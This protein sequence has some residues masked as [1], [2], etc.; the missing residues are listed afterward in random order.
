MLNYFLVAISIISLALSSYAY[1]S[2]VQSIFQWKIAK[3][4]N[5][6]LGF[7]III[8]VLNLLIYPVILFRISSGVFL[9]LLAILLFF[10]IIFY[11]RIQ[12]FNLDRTLIVFALIL[13]IRILVAYSRGIAEESFDTVHYLSYILEAA[14][15]SFLTEFDVNGAL[16][17]IVLPQDDFSSHFYILSSM[18][19]VVEFIKAQ[20]SFDIL[21]LTMPVI[22]WITT[23]FYY[24]LSISLTFVS[25]DVLN[26]KNRFHQL[27]V[28]LLTQ[29]FIGSFYYNSVFIFYGNTYR[30]LFAGVMVL[31][32]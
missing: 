9:L 11:K 15:G 3:Y 8:G 19:R 17:T 14:K 18:Y 26:V 20:L 25:M 23:I 29:F 10:P 13:L 7:I 4:I 32:I 21:T 12:W 6:I 31:F 5:V 2:I 30:T 1:G 28:I 24:I 22:I 16:R 27:I